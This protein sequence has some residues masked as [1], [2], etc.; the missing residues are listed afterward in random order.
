[1]SNSFILLGTFMFLSFWWFDRALANWKKDQDKKLDEIK[2][3]VDSLINKN[4]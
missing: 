4:Y 1:M 3:A 2:S